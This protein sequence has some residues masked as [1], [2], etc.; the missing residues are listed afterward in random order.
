M[1]PQ[2]LIRRQGKGARVSGS[3]ALERYRDAPQRTSIS[4][5]RLPG[6]RVVRVCLHPDEVFGPAGNRPALVSGF[7]GTLISAGPPGGGG[8]A[9]NKQ[10]RTSSQLEWTDHRGPDL[11]PRAGVWSPESEVDGRSSG[12]RYD[13]KRSCPAAAAAGVST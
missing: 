12:R 5:R 9:R 10:K 2:N 13:R 6:G 8:T 3:G 11:W 1:K 4:T 7:Q